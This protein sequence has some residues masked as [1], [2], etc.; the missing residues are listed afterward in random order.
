MVTDIAQMIGPEDE[1]I[2][3]YKTR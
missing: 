2:A 1:L 3:G